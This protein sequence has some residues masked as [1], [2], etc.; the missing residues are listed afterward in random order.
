[1]VIDGHVHACG[2]CLTVEKIKEY[3]ICHQI[4]AVVIC[5]GESNSQTDY[6]YPMMCKIF[7]KDSLGYFFNK[8]ICKVIKKR[9]M[10]QEI[11]YQNDIVWNMAKELPEQIFNAYWIN[12]LN[13]DCVDKMQ[14]FF[15]KKGFC[16]IKLH[17]CWTP[18]DVGGDNFNK[19]IT[20][21]GKKQIPIFIHLLSE[22]QVQKFIIIANKYSEVTFIVAHMIG[23]SCFMKNLISPNVYFDLSAPQLYSD[24]ILRKAIHKYGTYRFLAG[25]DTPYGKNNFEKVRRR[26]ET[27]EITDKEQDTIL[28]GNLKKILKLD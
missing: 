20:W 26:L 15:E 5:G 13:D 27:L 18:F 28:G 19:I 7:R 16:E 4:D 11:D 3:M 2:S 25:S 1:M 17:Q 10:S 24:Y 23:F 9:Q 22:V 12:P 14:S 8:I 6:I 21:A